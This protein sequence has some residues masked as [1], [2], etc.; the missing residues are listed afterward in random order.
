[1]NRLRTLVLLNILCLASHAMQASSPTAPEIPFTRHVLPNGLTVILHPDHRLPA[2][3]VNLW[4]FV[5]S[6][7]EPAGRSGFAHL[8][9]H[10]MFMG[11]EKVPYP[12]FDTI[13]EAAGGSNN[14]STSEDRTNYF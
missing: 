6:K 14:A 7:D 5:G 10:L 8:F 3:C 4:Y 11:T 12:K 9:E 1:M 13:M 2:V